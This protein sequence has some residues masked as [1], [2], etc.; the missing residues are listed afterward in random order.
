[1]RGCSLDHT[2]VERQSYQTDGGDDCEWA[3]EVHQKANQAREAE[4][5]LDQGGEDD[6]ARNL[7][8]RSSQ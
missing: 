2:V 6:A 8:Q 3:N 1:M 4:E 7:K 5:Y